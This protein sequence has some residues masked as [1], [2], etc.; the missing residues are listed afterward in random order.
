MKIKMKRP[1]KIS[2]KDLVCFVIVFT[3]FIDII[4]GIVR[5]A[6]LPAAFSPGQIMRIAL[7]FVMFLMLGIG[8]S[9]Y[10]AITV[11]VLGWLVLRDF[12]YSLV[13]GC[14]FTAT[15]SQDLRYV[16]VL[17][18][19]FLLKGAY[20]TSQITWKEMYQVMKK[21]IVIIVAASLF[22]SVTGM[23]MDYAGSK[24]IFTE[25]NALTA[26]LVCGGGIFLYETITS[27]AKAKLKNLLI[28]AMI[29][30]V[31]LS[32]ATKA[33]IIGM[34]V[35]F[36]YV[37]ICEGVMKKKFIKGL[38]FFVTILAGIY[39]VYNH[40]TVGTG[41]EIFNRWK[42]FYE[43][44]DLLSFLLSGRNLLFME[45]FA[46]WK[47]DILFVLF[48]TGYANA[49]ILLHNRNATI[50]Y[51]GTEMDLFDIGF[52]FGIVALIIV[53]IPIIKRF[54]KAAKNMGRK[55][56][57]YMNFF[58]CILCML[59]FLGGHVLNSPFAGVLFCLLSMMVTGKRKSK[60]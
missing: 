35:C 31:I 9:R 22:C 11:V 49:H 21:Y 39:V 3:P 14:S 57:N 41:T 45:S 36:L 51:S 10:L 12:I 38:L 60:E 54:L 2:W 29:V 44:L 25:V 15:L 13:Y 5:L 46:V 23:G 6:G 43:R 33:G 26:V 37:M 16:Y 7:L 52:Y 27:H 32:Q 20:C 42:Y 24:R 34:C 55:K 56:E 18:F 59:S 53:G 40:Y 28:T 4:T 19:Y 30:Y 50:S 1:V 48:G 58:Y 17:T 8:R 47:S